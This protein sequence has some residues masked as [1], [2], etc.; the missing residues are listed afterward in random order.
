MWK[1]V[2]PDWTRAILCKSEGEWLDLPLLAGEERI[3]KFT[4]VKSVAAKPRPALRF[5][6]REY[7]AMTVLA[8][9]AAQALQRLR[10]QD[11]SNYLRQMWA[12]VLH[13]F[14]TPAHNIQNVW[15]Q[16]R[17]AKDSDT[18]RGWENTLTTEIELLQSRCAYAIEAEEE[19][20][21]RRGYRLEELDLRE[22][23]WR[24][25]ETHGRGPHA[26]WEVEVQSPDRRVG[27][28]C[29]PKATHDMVLA[30]LEN[31]A[32]HSGGS[33]IAIRV[34]AVA[35]A[36]FLEVTDNGVGI[37]EAYRAEIFRPYARVPGRRQGRG[38]GL[39]LF[40]AREVTEA[41]G[42]DLTLE[43]GEPGHTTF[44]FTFPR[45]AVKEGNGCV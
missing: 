40:L 28:Y 34:G 25:R 27:A 37:P 33:A 19:I 18:R 42:G 2:D 29:D 9:L 43:R 31:A 22:V 17:C 21:G 45:E 16:L 1:L 41:Q 4:I 23:V 10:D 20:A 7:T 15:A 5:T 3:G 26:S 6:V 12:H 36:A 14:V 32:V 38:T 8:R 24:V 39:G 11:Q 13:S 44:R 35:G 30:V